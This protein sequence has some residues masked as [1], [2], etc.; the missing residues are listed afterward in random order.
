MTRADDSAVIG[1]L[2]RALSAVAAARV[3]LRQCAQE[4]DAPPWAAGG[5]AD[6]LDAAEASLCAA[7]VGAIN[8][9]E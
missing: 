6:L 7:I 4:A 2:Q 5:A 1:L 9:H 3:E 8:D